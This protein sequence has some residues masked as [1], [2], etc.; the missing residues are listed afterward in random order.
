M[1]KFVQLTYLTEEALNELDGA[2][3]GNMALYEQDDPWLDSYFPSR[4]YTKT[5]SVAMALP[6]LKCDTSLTEA[7]E[8]LVNTWLLYD[9]MKDLTP[10]QANSRQLWTYLSHVTYYEYCLDRWQQPGK[11]SW[12]ETR[13]FVKG[14]RGMR[15]LARHAISRLWWFG[16]LTYDAD[17]SNP[18]HYTETLLTAE[19]ACLDLLDNNYSQSREVMRG[20][21]KAL[22]DYVEVKGARGITEPWRDCVQ[23]VNRIGATRDLDFLGIDEVAEFAF[24]YLAGWKRKS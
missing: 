15:G 22:S 23:Y 9:A 13:M 6:T 10:L 17:A 4:Q 11:M 12:I 14:D 8:D 20:M 1:A 18:Y 16:Y 2:K 24:S 7:E 3:T 5:S 19:Q 21:L